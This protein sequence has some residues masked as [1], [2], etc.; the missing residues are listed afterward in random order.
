MKTAWLGCV[1]GV[2]GCA[3][4][5]AADRADATPAD[6]S[7]SPSP[8]GFRV[9]VESIDRVGIVRPLPEAAVALDPSE[10]ERVVQRTDARGIAEFASVREG[11]VDVTVARR[12]QI[13]RSRLDV[14]VARAEVVVRLESIEPLASRAV[15][16]V[17]RGL[18]A[19]DDD[20]LL[21]L[22]TYGERL[23]IAPTAFRID[24]PIGLASVLVAAQLSHD[25]TRPP[26]WRT[27]DLGPDAL[28][29]TIALDFARAEP[30][31][32]VIDM[33]VSL[34]NAPAPL[35]SAALE[36]G[37]TLAR[38][39]RA[40][41]A[42]GVF[43]RG[44]DGQT[45][46]R[47]SLDVLLPDALAAMPLS[48]FCRALY[49]NG[50]PVAGAFS[51]RWEPGAP[52]STEVAMTLP[53]IPAVLPPGLRSRSTFTVDASRP[54]VRYGVRVIGFPGVRTWEIELGEGASVGRIPSLPSGALA[55][56][57]LSDGPTAQLTACEGWRENTP[58]PRLAASAR[59]RFNR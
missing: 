25:R 53:T 17:V 9:R 42:L 29:S 26:R 22:S 39:P 3:A 37:L 5:T 49:P 2:C 4:T 31:T 35:A 21:T 16:G 48:T 58:C 1:W 13:A 59:I 52:A 43:H 12:G 15:E 56:S 32:R 7:I 10:G 54:G 57:I 41:L 24:A 33:S 38:P 46:A 45:G 55:S 18:V 51:E 34:P 40:T 36:C 20:V 30:S 47:G 27:I 6:H 28:A 23:L 8:Q 44:P 19:P 50:S 11:T 14:P